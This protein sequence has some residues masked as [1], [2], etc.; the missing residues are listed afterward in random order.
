MHFVLCVCLFH[1]INKCVFQTA[2]IWNIKFAWFIFFFVER[3]WLKIENCEGH[4]GLDLHGSPVVG[5][6][7][8]CIGQ[9]SDMLGVDAVSVLLCS[10]AS[11]DVV[12]S[13][14]LEAS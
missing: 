6:E 10:V 14:V 7:G 1:F 5:Q 2:D 9:I 12:A 11:T 4:K 3:A 13:D 8:N